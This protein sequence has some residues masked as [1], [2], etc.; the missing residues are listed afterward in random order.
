M[1]PIVR[2]AQATNSASAAAT[3][4]SPTR[5][6]GRLT[7]DLLIYV[8]AS[9]T[10]T[11]PTRPG[12][13]TGVRGIADAAFHLDICR[14]QEAGQAQPTWSKAASCKWAAVVLCI[15]AG[16]WDTTTPLDVENGQ[17]ESS[18]TAVALHTTP[19]VTVTV[20]DCL[21]VAGFGSNVAATWTTTDT[22]P[23]MLEAGDTAA[24]GTTPATC[25]V[26]HSGTNAVAT[27][28]ISR[29][30]TATVTSINAGMWLAAV[31][32]ASSTPTGKWTELPAGQKRNPTAHQTANW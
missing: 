16:T 32:P 21:L 13:V 17:I 24:S 23:P 22:A 25:A 30:A 12:T 20:D 6:A 14:Q 11:A 5:P 31:R 1:P 3:T 15:Q 2:T 10:T 28:S 29:T 19:A 7:D 26:Y 18:G 4:F 9:S 27:G 8:V